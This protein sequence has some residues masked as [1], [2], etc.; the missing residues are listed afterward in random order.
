MGNILLKI[1]FKDSDQLSK[2]TKAP[3]II[4]AISYNINVYNI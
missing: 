4:L 3:A 1:H 2:E